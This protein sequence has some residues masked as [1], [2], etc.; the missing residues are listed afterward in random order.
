M[1]TVKRPGSD[2]SAGAF[3]IPLCVFVALLLGACGGGDGVSVGS[4]QDQ[5]P[6]IVDFPI[7][8]IKVPLPVDDQGVFVESDAREL[9]TFNFGADLYFRDRASP[10]ALDINITGNETNGLGAVRDID[11]SW[12]GT[13]LLFAMRGPVDLDLDLDDEDQPT[14]N[15]WEYD[16]PGASLRRV[17]ASDLTAGIGHDVGPKYLPD[18]RILFGSTRQL[19]SN[20][21]LLDEGKP[22]FA[23]QDEDRNE[24]AFLLHVMNEDGTG[25]EQVSFNQSHD[26]DA[27]VLV[28]GQIVFSRWDNAGTNNVINL[29]RMNPDGSQ[30]ELLY[31]QNSHATGTNG[32]VI[33]FLQPHQLE[34]GRIM[35][36]VRPF[37]DTD[38]G[39]DIVTIDTDVYVENTQPNRDN[40]G[41]TGP[42][43]QA[44]TINEVSTLAGSPSPGG[45]FRS[46]YPVQDGTGRILTSWSQCRLTDIAPPAAGEVRQFYPCTAAN[47]S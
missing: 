26:M 24:D 1:N 14:W 22:Q 31:G 7:A 21:V 44:A 4:G 9:I 47:L 37:T 30:L 11:I 16:I 28:N 35:S 19:R 33:Q 38:D 8:Y 13:R 20:A 5:D 27:S 6:V 12:D 41:L 32:E 25:I 15:I 34:D 29:Y 23:A 18:G 17:I 45:R 10:S 3:R 39:G 36:L 2:A 46:I 40:T 42:A 43:Q